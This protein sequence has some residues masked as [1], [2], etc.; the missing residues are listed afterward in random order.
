M[1]HLRPLGFLYKKLAGFKNFLYDHDYFHSLELPISVL[2]LGNLTM[3]GTGK[4]PVTD[5]CLRYFQ[6]RRLKVAV[7]SRNYR[8]QVKEVAQVDL[9]RK[10]AAAYFGDEPVLLAERNPQ[11]DF[12]VGPYKFETAQYALQKVS[13]QLVIVDDGFQ[14]RQ[15]YRD[16]DLV[17]L[18]ATEPF[19]NYECVPAGRA[20]ESWESLAR[21]T[22]FIITKTNLADP[23][24]VQELC[25]RLKKF[26]K[27]LILMSYELQFLRGD[28]S[29]GERNL[30]QEQGKNFFLVSAIG[31]PQSFEK[32]LEKFSVRIQEHL[33]FQDHHQYS[34]RDVEKILAKWRE[35]GAQAG[36][37]DLLTTEKDYVKLKSLWPKEVPLWYAPLE[38]HIQSQEEIFYEILDQV[39]H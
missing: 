20:R 12:F 11:V 10:D 37:G 38:V 23:E 30:K 31:Q 7:V 36:A 33:V 35:A 2:S 14:H 21:A 22:A 16:I 32:N 6:H 9:K 8:A 19:E 26:D 18:D 17:I 1:S 27:P 39:L 4:T 24:H 29:L 15:L 25:A 34:A 28:S 3:G 13:P 5:F